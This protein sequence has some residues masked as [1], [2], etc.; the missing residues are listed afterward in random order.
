[1]TDTQPV[2]ISIDGQSLVVEAHKTVAVVLI[3]QQAGR[4]AVCGERREALCGMGIC[5]EC[6]ATVDGMADVRTCLLPVRDGM[7]VVTH[8]DAV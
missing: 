3:D 8:A 4:T 7:K 5:W 6:R 2:T 1:M